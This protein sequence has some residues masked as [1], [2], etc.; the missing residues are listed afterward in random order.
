[1]VGLSRRPLGRDDEPKLVELAAGLGEEEG[2]ENAFALL[3]SWSRLDSGLRRL[4][5]AALPNSVTLLMPAV[6]VCF[7]ASLAL[8]DSELT[9]ELI[10]FFRSPKLLAAVSAVA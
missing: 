1:M 2:L 6:A 8:V 7:A 10:D 4:L 5:L 3:R 9:P